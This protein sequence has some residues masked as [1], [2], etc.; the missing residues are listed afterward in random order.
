MARLLARILAGFILLSSVGAKAAPL[1]G[2][3]DGPPQANTPAREA[4]LN[5]SI[6]FTWDGGSPLF[7]GDSPLL[8]SVM[9]PLVDWLNARPG[10]RA[11][12][13]LGMFRYSNLP[14]Q[15]LAACAAGSY[16]SDYIAVAKAFQ[17]YGV[18]S[19]IFRIGWEFDGNWFSWSSNGHE[20]DYAACYRR[21]VQVMRA[22]VPGNRWKFDWN[23]TANAKMATLI[24][25]YPGDDVVD[26]ITV[27]IYDT[28]RNVATAYPYPNPCD[29]A[30]RLKRQQ[31]NWNNILYELKYIIGPF[32]MAHG[33]PIGFT[34]WGVWSE[35][36]VNGSTPGGGDNPYF[37]QQ[38]YNYINDP[39]NNV[40]YTVYFE[41][42]PP[43]GNHKL[44]CAPSETEFPKSSALF[45][46]LFSQ[47]LMMVSSALSQATVPQGGTESATVTISSTV[48]LASGIL[49]LFVRDAKTG[50]TVLNSVTTVS[51]NPTNSNVLQ[52]KF[53]VPVTTVGAGD[54]FV[55]MAIYDQSYKLL[56]YENKI[57]N[58]S[59]LAR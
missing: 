34:E 22:T 12:F 25:T 54:Y 27:D 46:K 38:M 23:P 5:R 28:S 33:K 41:A 31:A 18:L 13:S 2:F 14:T 35:A 26:Y 49:T 7:F 32:A 57:G 44:C 4:W 19:N 53:S 3:Y 30:C 56:L 17:Q 36:G 6:M 21:I 51:V 40:A 52:A 55:T 20:A 15:T 47:P 58:F 37:I 59:V 42:N 8:P 24:A 50:Q 9:Q 43:G 11:V 16:D 29:D 45:Q 39:A 10:R 1:L 48:T